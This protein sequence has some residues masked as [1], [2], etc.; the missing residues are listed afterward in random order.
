MLSMNLSR[1]LARS[2]STLVDIRG[3]ATELP[4]DFNFY[5]GILGIQEQRILLGAALEKLNATE[6]RQIRRHRAA[7]QE[8]QEREALEQPT[9]ILKLFLPDA[10]YQFEEVR[11]YPS[12]IVT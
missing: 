4:H 5:P 12:S 9:D 11:F 3:P 10:C 6:S 1:S 2:L 8:K 7:V